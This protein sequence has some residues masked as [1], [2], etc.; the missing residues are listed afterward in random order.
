MRTRFLASV[1]CLSLVANPQISL[2]APPAGPALDAAVEELLGRMTLAEKL[3]QMSQASRQPYADHLRDTKELVR[4]G[5]LGSILNATTRD[6]VEEFQRIAVEESRLKIPLLFGLDVIHGYRTLFPIPLAQS[7]SWN[8]D[9]VQKAARIAAVEA[10]AEGIRWTFAPMLDLTRDARWGRIAETVGEDPLLASRMGAAMVRGFQGDDLSLPTSMAACGKHFVG[11]GA[12]EAGRDYNTTLIPDTELR[13]AYLPAFKA[14]KDA[15]VLTYMSAF[16]D[17]NGVPTSANPRVLR[18]ILRDEWAFNG[19]VV[20]DW[21][22]VD[23]LIPHGFAADGRQAAQRAIAGGVD[24]EMVSPHYRTFGADLIAKNE[25]PLAF[26]D[27]SVR[28][29][30]RV[31]FQLGL[32]D[33]PFTAKETPRTSKNPLS[34]EHLAVAREL[35]TQSIVLLKND[36]GLLPLSSATKSIAVIGPLADSGD[37]MRGC[38]FCESSPGDTITPLA[39]LK[40]TLGPRAQI[41]HAPGTKRDIDDSTDAFAAAVK[42]AKKA[43]VVILCLGEG[44]DLAGE[45]RSRAFLNLPGTQEKLFDAIAATGKPIVLVIFAGR[46]LVFPAQFAK[47]RAVFYAWHPGTMAGPALA[48]LLLGTANPSAKLTVSFPRTVG[49]IPIYYNHRNT[50]RPPQ[51]ENVGIPMGT[52]Q[53]PQGYYSKF[54]DVHSTPEFPFGHGLSYTTFAYSDLQVTAPSG[55]NGTLTVSAV[56]KNTGSRDGV[57]IAQLYTRDLIG[58]ITRPVRELKGFERV[59][60]KSGESRTITFNVPASELGFFNEDGRY[61]VEPGKFHV[62]VGGSSTATLIGEFEL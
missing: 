56:I 37:D 58:Q 7:C 62:W 11:Y 28:R 31:K 16:N 34:A 17:L 1:A 25:L 51:K 35:A 32:F 52:P 4:Q 53:D 27:D 2:A 18:K 44:R 14:A 10:T 5:A 38:W 54:I 19:F 48:D 8:P 26:I 22:S 23:E 24:M 49:Q 29:I 39:A 33:H 61:I 40:E 41:L 59:P 47:A 60:L 55:T 13:N 21:T 6:Q 45:A 50:G 57:E 36:R 46:P 12:A 20:S 43:D 15:G 3:G 42:A 30:L 9:L